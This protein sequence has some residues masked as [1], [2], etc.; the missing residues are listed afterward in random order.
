MNLISS[1]QAGS[2]ATS[3][4]NGQGVNHAIALIGVGIVVPLILQFTLGG[5]AQLLDPAAMARGG[6]AGMLAAFG[7]TAFLVGIVNFVVQTGS[8]Y[9]SWRIGL[10]GG[11]EPLGAALGYGLVHGMAVPL[12]AVEVVL[13]FGIGGLDRM[14]VVR[15]KRGE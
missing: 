2:H 6:E 7:A 9:A 5:S 13:V 8:Y 10:T 1:S 15:G 3:F 14:G 12:L 11:G 4:F